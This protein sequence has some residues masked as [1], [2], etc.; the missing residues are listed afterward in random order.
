VTDADGRYTLET[1]TTPNKD[2]AVPGKHV[3][4]IRLMS[5]QDS[6]DD[7]DASAETGLPAQAGSGSLTFEVPAEGTES[8]DFDLTSK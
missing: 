2:G 8:A 4:R 6:A 5:Q 3:V 7:A 1:V